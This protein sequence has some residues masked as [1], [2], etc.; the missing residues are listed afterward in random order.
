MSKTKI[1][2][3]IPTLNAAS[4]LPKLLNS[5]YSQ[6]RQP[7][8]II[9]V[10]SESDDDTCMITTQYNRVI[11]I[12]IKRKEFN[13][14]ATRKLAVNRSNGDYILF[15]T[16]DALP[17]NNNYIE[18]I[19]RPFTKDN[20]IV[21]AGGR[22]IAWPKSSAIQVHV[23]NFNYPSSAWVRSSA[24]LKKYGMKT[25]FLSDV[26]SAYR[27]DIY[28]R[29]G[30][31]DTTIFGED[32][33]F[34]AKIINAGYKMA[35]V[36]SAIVYHSHDYSLYDEYKRNYLDGYVREVNKKLLHNASVTKEG[37]KLFFYVMHNLL[38]GNNYLELLYF[39]LICLA[40]LLGNKTGKIVAIK[41]KRYN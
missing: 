21:V 7:D 39:P 19:I 25:F 29:F 37:K 17:A 20:E 27:R 4:T 15:T 16:Q 12:K 13:H 18:N 2:V 31:H 28:D 3:I 23:R 30:G 35:Y 41:Q 10:D 11:L 8:E 22:Q 26:C 36:P 33:L 38:K 32:M 34:A 1:S 14:G 5:L 9:I 40:K 24:D 6:T